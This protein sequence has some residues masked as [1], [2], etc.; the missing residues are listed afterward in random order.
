LPHH[1]IP[2]DARVSD[3]CE[4]RAVADR[5]LLRRP[6]TK[7]HGR[8]VG[9]FGDLPLSFYPAITLQWARRRRVTDNQQLASSPALPGLGR[10]CIF[11]RQTTWPDVQPTFDPAFGYDHNT[12]IRT[13]ANLK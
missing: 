8:H 11:G 10:D 4:S 2:F 6:G 1:G 9:T 5:R 13:S 3:L 7:L 12:S